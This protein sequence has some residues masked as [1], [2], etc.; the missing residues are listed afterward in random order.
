MINLLKRLVCI[1]LL[2][3]SGLALA[4]S[5][6]DFF[7]AIKKNNAFAMKNLLSRGLDPNLISPGKVPGL[8]I[9]LRE[10]SFAVVHVLLS[11][12]ELNIHI[13]SPEEES[14]LM[15]AALKGN[16][17]ICLKLIERDADV[18]KT[19][20]TPLHYAAT[21]GHVKLIQLL[22]DN[23]AYIDAASPNG[24]TPL[25][26]AAMYGSS[27]AVKL[28]LDSGADWNLKNEQNLSALNFAMQAKKID[29]VEV[30]SAFIR[31]QGSPNA[32]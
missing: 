20:W 4:G 9:A 26:M 31:A 14:P 6:D 28:L 8:L 24:T 32:W 15:L 16:Y 22:L 2:A 29:A 12:P 11:H 13:L 1:F 27:S 10:S 23:F 17:E 5:Y 18:N 25:M 30:I 7:M 21:G 3:A 19:G